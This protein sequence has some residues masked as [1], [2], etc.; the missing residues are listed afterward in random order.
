MKCKT[1]SGPTEKNSAMP[2]YIENIFAL[3]ELVSSKE[4]IN[5]YKNDFNEAAIRYGDLK[6][7]LAEDMVAFVAPIRKRATDLMANE[8]L[9]NQILQ[10]GAEKANISANATMKMVR[11]ALGFIY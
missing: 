5:K 8:S 3:M 10:Q 6:K 7:D 4:K 2:D 9:L 1:D 11:E